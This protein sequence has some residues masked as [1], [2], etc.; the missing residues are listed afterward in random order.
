MTKLPDPNV[1]FDPILILSI[2]FDPR[3]INNLGQLRYYLQLLHRGKYVSFF[4]IVTSCSIIAPELIIQL[5]LIFEPAFIIQLL[6]T[7]IPSPRLARGDIKLFFEIR[8]I[9][10]TNFNFKIFKII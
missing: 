3:P 8:L 10:F 7:K 1:V 9:N 4:P 2:M 5:S 6:L